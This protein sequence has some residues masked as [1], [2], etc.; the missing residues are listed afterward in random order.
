M[1]ILNKSRFSYQLLMLKEVMTIDNCSPK[2]PCSKPYSKRN[3]RINMAFLAFFLQIF[4]SSFYIITFGN[5]T[6]PKKIWKSLKSA[7]AGVQWGLLYCS[8]IRWEVMGFQCCDSRNWILGLPRKRIELLSLSFLILRLNP[9][10]SEKL[11]RKFT[12]RIG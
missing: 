4:I 8:S 2:M 5:F 10:G 12:S 9:Y 1:Q 7:R 11:N 6:Q 3:S